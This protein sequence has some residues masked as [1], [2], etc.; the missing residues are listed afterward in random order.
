[1]NYFDKPRGHFTDITSNDECFKITVHRDY[2]EYVVEPI[3]NESITTEG[4]PWSFPFVELLK[5]VDRSKKWHHNIVSQYAK[6]DIDNN[7]DGRQP[8]EFLMYLNWFLKDIGLITKTGN[9]EESSNGDSDNIS[10]ASSRVSDG[11]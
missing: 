5:L 10:E 8:F 3:V 11:K 7:D 9:S 1:M 2:A 4:L 6:N